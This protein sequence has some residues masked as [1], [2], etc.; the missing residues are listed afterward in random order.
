MNFSSEQI[1]LDI[2][3]LD[4]NTSSIDLIILSI[5]IIFF[6]FICLIVALFTEAKYEAIK[7]KILSKQF[8]FTIVTTFLT[9]Y[10]IRI[11]I[12]EY[13]G[14]D[15]LVDI[16]NYISIGYYVSM[17]ALSSVFKVLFSD[18]D[19]V[20][21][22]VMFAD[23]ASAGSGSNTA[24]PS[25]TGPSSAG[26]GAGGSGSGRGEGSNKSKAMDN[27]LA[28]PNPLGYTGNSYNVSLAYKVKHLV[29]TKLSSGSLTGK[30]VKISDINENLSE[31]ELQQIS[32]SLLAETRNAYNFHMH[33]LDDARIYDS[34]NRY[35]RIN[36]IGNS[37]V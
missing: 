35:K 21:G 1:T 8:L 17:S 11:G 25:T 18:L 9:G 31:A 24:G 13:L 27:I 15:V 22:S 4:F 23:N 6:Y 5:G 16:Y 30:V 34:T 28:H 29:D 20:L 12:R 14:V 26:S 3:G 36:Q 19:K 7:S 33:N 32:K 2:L 10:F 37:N